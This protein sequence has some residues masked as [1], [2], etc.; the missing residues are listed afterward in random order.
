L[1]ASRGFDFSWIV[2]DSILLPLREP[3]SWSAI[4]IIKHY[5]LFNDARRVSVLWW[6][7]IFCFLCV[8]LQRTFFVEREWRQE[9]ARKEENT[10]KTKRNST[11]WSKFPTSLQRRR[12]CTNLLWIER[13]GC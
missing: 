1:Q 5:L 4:K 9:S 2:I 8:C 6:I 10:T 11:T 13:C 7:E 3:S 12:P